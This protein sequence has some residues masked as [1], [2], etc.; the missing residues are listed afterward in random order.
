MRRWITALSAG[1]TR[2]MRSIAAATSSRAVN[3]LRATRSACAVASR[4]ARSSTEI[5]PGVYKVGPIKFD[6]AGIWTVRFHFFE[7]CGDAR[8]DSPHGHAAF[9]VKVP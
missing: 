1:S 9:Y 5:A 7:E 3:S 8:E 6:A 4:N 2:S